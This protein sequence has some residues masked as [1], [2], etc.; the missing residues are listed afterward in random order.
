[1]VKI[2]FI[3]VGNMGGL[4][5]VNLIKV[6]YQVK[7]YDL[8]VQFVENV[9]VQSQVGIGSVYIVV[10]FQE[11]VQDVEFVILMLLFGK[12]VEDFYIYQQVIFKFMFV[13]ILVI[14]CFIIVVENVINVFNVVQVLGIYMLDVSV[15]GGVGGVVVGMFIF[16]VGGDQVVFEKVN[17]IL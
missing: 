4:M 3:G 6:G 12:I 7:V 10:L 16:I 17:L 1:M 11:V 9:V 15:F 5:V 14:D 8:F 13:Q 2:G